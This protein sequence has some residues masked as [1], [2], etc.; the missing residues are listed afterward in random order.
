MLKLNIADIPIE[1]TNNN[2]DLPDSFLLFKNEVKDSCNLKI[3]INTTNY[4]TY[5]NNIK[6]TESEI[7]WWQESSTLNAGI[8]D[9][10]NKEVVLTLS[11]DGQ[12]ENALLSHN[13][14]YCDKE[15]TIIGP[16]GELL[17]RNKILYNDGLVIHAAAIECNGKGIIFS[18]PSE[19]GKSTQARLWKEYIGA[20]ILNGDR[21]AVRIFNNQAYVYGTP[22]SGSSNDFMN[23]KAPLSAII[24]LQQ[25][26]V[27]TIEKLTPT[28]A[29]ANLMPRCFLPYHSPR[30][31]HLAINNLEKVIST[32]PVFLLKCRPDYE[33]VELVYQCI[34]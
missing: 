14:N 26:P 4:I 33:A 9:S 20:S 2:L 21:P 8:Y 25:A 15:Y 29:I 27:N 17:F 23:S 28:K 24:V 11:M 5:P 34:R 19:T 30:L 13:K 1:V 18:A 32:T 22:W 10:K 3:I 12:C 31:L 7:N 16:L 6:L